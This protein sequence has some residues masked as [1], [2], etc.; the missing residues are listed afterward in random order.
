RTGVPLPAISPKAVRTAGPDTTGEELIKQEEMTEDD[1]QHEE[2]DVGRASEALQRTLFIPSEGI[3]RTVSPPPQESPWISPPKQDQPSREEPLINFSNTPNRPSFHARTPSCEPPS[4]AIIPE[5]ASLLSL[6]DA[7]PSPTESEA[8]IIHR[9]S[10]QRMSE[11][12]EDVPSYRHHG[13][14]DSLDPSHAASPS[15]HRTL[16]TP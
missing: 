2:S 3:F 14:T 6:L 4:A 15:F 8:T 1:E 5:G 9:Q 16:T 13:R 7:P 12:P 11:A 10:P